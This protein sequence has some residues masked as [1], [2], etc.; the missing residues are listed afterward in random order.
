MAKKKTKSKSRSRR[1]QSKAGATSR[2][3]LKE[4]LSR[5]KARRRETER[6]RSELAEKLARAGLDLADARER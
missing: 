3:S 6:Y 4:I 5:M 2:L 1:G